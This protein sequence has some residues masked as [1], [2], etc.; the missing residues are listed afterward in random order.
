MLTVAQLLRLSVAL[1]S[2]VYSR[3]R[4]VDVSPEQL[5]KSIRYWISLSLKED[6]VIPRGLLVFSRMFLLNASYDKK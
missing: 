1:T 2:V 3:R 6:P 5:R 4:S